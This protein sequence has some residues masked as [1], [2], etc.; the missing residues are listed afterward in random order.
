MKDKKL[1]TKIVHSFE[2]EEDLMEDLDF[3]LAPPKIKLKTK[4]IIVNVKKRKL[5]VDASTRLF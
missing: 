4:T 2:V 1:K 5:K 3:D